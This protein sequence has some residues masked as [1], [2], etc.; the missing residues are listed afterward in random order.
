[1]LSPLDSGEARQLQ[2]ALDLLAQ[3]RASTGGGRW[4]HLEGP[5]R[6]N[7]ELGLGGWLE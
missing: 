5:G 4:V 7:D 3:L 1:L 6:S 2:A